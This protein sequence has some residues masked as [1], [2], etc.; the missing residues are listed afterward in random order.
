MRTFSLL[1]LLAAVGASFMAQRHQA[2]QQDLRWTASAELAYIPT[3]TVPVNAA[4]AAAIERL[5]DGLE[6]HD[7]VQHVFSNEE[8][9]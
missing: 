2:R 6:E 4:G 9:S 5:H 7:D 3:S 8:A 1:L